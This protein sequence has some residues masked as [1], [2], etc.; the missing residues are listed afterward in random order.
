VKDWNS[1]EYDADA[2]LFV[3]TPRQL[4]LLLALV[5]KSRE[6]NVIKL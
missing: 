4:E 1:A 5:E 2:V 3:F 6:R